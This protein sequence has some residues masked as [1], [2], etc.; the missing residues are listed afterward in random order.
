MANHLALK[1]KK[2]LWFPV[3][4]LFYSFLYVYLNSTNTSLNHKA[5][6]WGHL[7]TEPAIVNKYNVGVCFPYFHGTVVLVPVL[8]E[9]GVFVYVKILGR[10]LETE[11]SQED[12][13]RLSLFVHLRCRNDE[14]L[15]TKYSKWI[16]M[17]GIHVAE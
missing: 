16:M 1:R 12:S 8:L 6:H 2:Q 17:L 9:M 3:L 7:G 11:R 15:G 13:V 5:H 4:L 10:C 14:L